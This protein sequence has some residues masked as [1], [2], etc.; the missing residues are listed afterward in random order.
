V[1]GSRTYQGLFG[2]ELTANPIFAPFSSTAS[3]P[4]SHPPS[5][6]EREDGGGFSA[7]R[8]PFFD[9]DLIGRVGFWF[10]D[11]KYSVPSALSVVNKLI[12]CP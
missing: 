11:K 2:A 8:Y 12:E 3:S 5:K 9:W 7:A 10:F 6:G 4:N 1:N